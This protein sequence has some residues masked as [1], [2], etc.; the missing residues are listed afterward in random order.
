MGRRLYVGNISFRVTEESLKEFF[1]KA[2]AVVSTKLIMDAA[3]G[4]SRG[5]GFVEMESDAEAQKAI[6]ML[7]GS[8]FMERNLVVNEAR[9]QPEREQGASRGK[10]SYGEGQ[11][12]SSKR[13]RDTR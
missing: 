3:T 5:F 2:G 4:R 9:P 11:R 10:G 12:F 6:E 7:N 1:S 13:S 8:S